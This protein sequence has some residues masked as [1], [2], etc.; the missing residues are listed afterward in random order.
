[1]KGAKI[2]LVREINNILHERQ[3]ALERVQIL[4][5]SVSP[6]FTPYQELDFLKQVFAKTI[7]A[8][9]AKAGSQDLV[10]KN[11]KSALLGTLAKRT[12]QVPRQTRLG[13]HSRG[14]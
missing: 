4:W 7:T 2:G 13:N 3:S 1:L 9:E 5:N 6:G 14:V 11:P 10:I 8:G 12:D